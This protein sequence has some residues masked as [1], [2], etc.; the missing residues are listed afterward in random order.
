[1]SGSLRVTRGGGWKNSA[2]A[3]TVDSRNNLPPG[4]VSNQIGFRVARTLE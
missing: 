2:A 1:M 4:A 3:C